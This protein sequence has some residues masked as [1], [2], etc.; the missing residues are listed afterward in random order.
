MIRVFHDENFWKNHLGKDNPESKDLTLVAEVQTDD[1]E[2]AFRLTNH[3]EY[4]W[5]KNPEVIPCTDPTRSTSVGDLMEKD[6]KFFIVAS[7][8]FREVEDKDYYAELL[9][10]APRFSFDKHIS[11]PKEN[12]FMGKK[13]WS[14]M[15]MMDYPEFKGLSCYEVHDKLLKAGVVTDKTDSD[16]ESSCCYYYFYSKSA[17]ENFI[18][19]LNEYC[20]KKAELVAAAESF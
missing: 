6:G 9:A 1:L 14:F 17:A 2:D 3:I 7:C 4:D 19:R 8:G 11:T 10:P 13:T 16:H 20:Q 18:K 12:H 5:W 15:D